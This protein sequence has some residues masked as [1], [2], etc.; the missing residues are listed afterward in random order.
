MFLLSFFW[1][2]R[3]EMFYARRGKV[4]LEGGVHQ[5]R[6][7]EKQLL[8][9]LP[10]L[11]SPSC[12]SH[13]MPPHWSPRRPW[14][15][16]GVPLTFDLWP[17][18]PANS[19][20]SRQLKALSG[21]HILRN[22]DD[23][24]EERQSVQVLT[25]SAGVTDVLKHCPCP[26]PRY[27]QHIVSIRPT[28]SPPCLSRSECESVCV[29]MSRSHLSWCSWVKKRILLFLDG[30]LPATERSGY[31]SAALSSLLKKHVP[32][33]CSYVG[34]WNFFPSPLLLV[35]PQYK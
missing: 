5:T 12:S 33:L 14:M 30:K 31:K 16:A 6:Q 23:D 3:A 7:K 28:K 21:E 15:P 32:S 10:P 2:L 17:P 19:S 20:Q 25:V 9:P 4:G 8:P 27:S 1:H 26:S 11:F 35:F 13:W 18:A 29:C 22:S 34:R 24:R